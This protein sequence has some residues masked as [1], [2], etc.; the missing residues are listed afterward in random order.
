MTTAPP[1]PPLIE[2]RL[3]RVGRVAR[4]FNP[5]TRWFHPVLAVVWLYVIAGVHQWTHLSPWVMAPVGLAATAAAVLTVRR[6]YSEIDYGPQQQRATTRF[7]GVAGAIGTCWLVWT[8]SQPRQPPLAISGAAVGILAIGGVAVGAFY[9]MVTTKAPARKEALAEVRVVEQTAHQQAQTQVQQEQTAS[10]HRPLMDRAKLPGMKVIA[11][12]DTAA[13]YMLTILDNPDGPYKFGGLHDACGAI[14]SILAHELAPQGIRLGAHQVRAE[15]TDS[16]HTFHLHVSTKNVFR[17]NL[18]YR[19]DQPVTSIRQPLVPA[20]YED[21][22]PV[23]LTLY[24]RNAVHVGTTGS[25]KTV[26]ANNII[27]GATRTVDGKVWIGATSKLNPLVIPWLAPWLLGHTTEPVLDRVAGEDPQEVTDMLADFYHVV[28]LHNEQLGKESQ[29]IATPADP[30]VVCIIE[31]ASDLL[32]D[33]PH[34]KSKTHDGHLWN[35]SKIINAIARVDRSAGDSIYLLTQF[36]LMDA[37]GADGSK[38]KRNITVRIAGRTETAHDGYATLVRMNHVDTTKLDSNMVLV[39]PSIETPRAIPAKA[40]HLDGDELIAPVAHRN[41]SNQATLPAYITN[42]LGDR[43]AR[44]WDADRLPELVRAAHLSYGVTWPV[45]S[46]GS[47]PKPERVTVEAAPVQVETDEEAEMTAD[48]LMDRSDVLFEQARDKISKYGT[49][50]ATMSA[51]FDKIR[52]VNAPS[53][54]PTVQMARVIGR[55]GEEAAIVADLSEHPWKL[56]PRERDGQLGW[57]KADVLAAIRRHLTGDESPAA[58]EEVPAETVA[59]LTA[60]RGSLVFDER[61]DWIPTD[62]IF[63]AIAERMGWGSLVDGGRKLAEALAP[64][65]IE[66]SRPSVNGQKRMAYPVGALAAA[67]ERHAE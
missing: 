49:L 63:A 44:R 64:L 39:Q 50:G 57:L 11:K 45:T 65:G 48:E 38:A 28:C 46:S 52:A 61:Q 9:W 7:A 32:E 15:E 5:D 35:A 62:D 34:I 3:T 36:G 18:T 25:G 30:A 2:S 24:G 27:G 47:L 51:I 8:G 17:G 67:I 37:L 54:I 41:T 31:E 43:Y 16:A 19:F 29:R 42:E 22:K 40:F 53:F 56:A 55:P 1:Q 58:R 20:L 33:Y 60:L 13:G 14:A 10:E 66:S 4:R 12:T 6:L 26:F 21:G 59:L 23:E